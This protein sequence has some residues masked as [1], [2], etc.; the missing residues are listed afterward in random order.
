MSGPRVVSNSNLD[1]T[2][3]AEA[4][5]DK[6]SGQWDKAED[7]KSRTGAPRGSSDAMDFGEVLV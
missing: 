6:Y 2:V 3:V 7:D 5:P 1:A 4:A